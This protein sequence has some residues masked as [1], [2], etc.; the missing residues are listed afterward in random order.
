MLRL[1]ALLMAG[2]LSLSALA[3]ERPF[4]AHALRGKMTPGY[5][6]DISID[7]KPRRLSPAARIFNQDNMIEMP[8]ALRG[9]DIVV[10]YTVDMNGNI[11][12]IWILTPEEAAQ[13]LPTSVAK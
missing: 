8:A 6:P 5:F 13:K 11:D 3:F 12:R 9:S 7:G 1:F 2:L 4:P 10:N